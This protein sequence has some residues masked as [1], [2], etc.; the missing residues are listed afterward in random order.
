[1]SLFRRFG[2]LATRSVS[3]PFRGDFDLAAV[4]ASAGFQVVQRIQ[5]QIEFVLADEQAWWEWAWSHGMRGLFET[6]SSGHLDELRQEVFKQFAAL[7]T[8]EG[9]PLRQTATF[10][11]AQLP[12]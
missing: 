6:L 8:P 3:I 2:P 1:M 9:V 7:R 5:E 11:V 12:S 10:V 4:L